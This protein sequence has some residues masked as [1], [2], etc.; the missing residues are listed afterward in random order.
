MNKKTI[1]TNFFV[2]L[3]F[4]ITTVSSSHFSPKNEIKTIE[5]IPRKSHSTL[6]IEITKIKS[7]YIPGILDK[8]NK[9]ITID[10]SNIKNK[11]QS[12]MTI[13]ESNFS[14]FVTNSLDN[15]SSYSS[16]KSKVNKKIFPKY[17]FEKINDKVIKINFEEQPEKLYLIVLNKNTNN[18]QNIFK[19]NVE[20]SNL[21]T[22]TSRNIFISNPIYLTNNTSTNLSNFYPLNN[23]GTNSVKISNYNLKSNSTDYGISL[24][25]RIHNIGVWI[26]SGGNT[27]KTSFV[28]DSNGK[29]SNTKLMETINGIKFLIGDFNGTFGIGINQWDTFS[30]N[31]IK[32]FLHH[33]EKEINPIT[34]N[35]SQAFASDILIVNI[36]DLDPKVYF[37]N[38]NSTIKLGSNIFKTLVSSG[39]NA[40]SLGTIKLNN[41]QNAITKSPNSGLKF[42]GNN[43][44]TLS[45]GDG[46]GDITAQILIDGKPLSEQKLIDNLET[47]TRNI[48]LLPNQPLK[49]GKTYTASSVNDRILVLG[50]EGRGTT[51]ISSNS[52]SHSGIYADI[53]SN[54]SLQTTAIDDALVIESLDNSGNWSSINSPITFIHGKVIAGEKIPTPSI[55]K[56]FRVR[57]LNNAT[58][59]STNITLTINNQTSPL[60][61]NESSI[62]HSFTGVLDSNNNTATATTK[63]F[64]IIS[65]VPLTPLPINQTVGIYEKTSDVIINITQ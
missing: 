15:L 11:K 51:N 3:F 2:G 13:E 50:V 60:L 23:K 22:I 6:D 57:R 58:L 28:T 61:L 45:P 40:I 19:V 8:E 29:I 31:G 33:F 48:T 24:Y 32:I 16:N 34:A 62:P 43:M 63:I 18:I 35:A 14:L 17:N 10:F 56:N 5:T 64:S 55:N 21:T 4:L 52:I 1:K 53:I 7:Q 39:V 47:T 41:I 37:D 26:T 65:A 44:I 46:S 27:I 30:K 49:A 42:L 54:L 20:E 36:D 38:I 59:G 9:N 25:N 12:K